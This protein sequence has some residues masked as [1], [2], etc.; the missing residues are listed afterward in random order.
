M[1]A[2]DW[3][4]MAGRPRAR[5][6]LGAACI[7]WLAAAGAVRGQAVYISADREVSP[8]DYA[9][10]R[11]G[12]FYS[13]AALT[14]SVGYRY[15]RS[16]GVG[17]DYLIDNERGEIREDG[18]D[19]PII[20]TL[21]FRNYL[22]LSRHADVDAS[23]RISYAYYPLGTQENDWFFDL[24]EEG[25]YATISSSFRISPYL[26]GTLY[27]RAVYKT[28]YVDTR[29]ID[30]R[31]GGSRYEYFANTVGAQLDWHM[32]KDKTVTAT[33]SREDWFPMDDEFEDQERVSHRFGLRY[34]QELIEGLR[35][36]VAAGL[37]FTDYELETHEDTRQEDYSLF[38]EFDKGGRM[39]LPLSDRSTLTASLGVST[40][41]SSAASVEETDG[42]ETTE[43]SDDTTS[44]MTGNVALQTDLAKN[45]QH[46]L[47]YTRGVRDGWSS[48]EIY[49]GFSYDIQWTGDLTTLKFRSSI[50]SV[51]PALAEDRDYSDWQNQLTATRA[52]ADFLRNDFQHLRRTGRALQRRGNAELHARHLR[53]FP[54]LSPSVLI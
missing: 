34:A 38:A 21:T 50:N 42:E 17:T 44:A 4:G 33:T 36:G 49:D 23:F 48:T 41:Y 47:T 37:G 10:F 25:V 8:P 54:D 31:Y 14:E 24:V 15:T 51:D 45:L 32:A 26:T 40:I 3:L 39:G 1:K 9:T 43:D 12:P 2:I 52:L 16:S 19:L 6:A 27:E 5:A 7:L 46:T 13:T 18:S 20:S 35:V 22:I 53:G 30:D 29:G 28:D 11:L